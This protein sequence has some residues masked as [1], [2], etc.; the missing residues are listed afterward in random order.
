M[1]RLSGWQFSSGATGKV[2]PS[3]YATSSVL[4][5][6]ENEGLLIDLDNMFSTQFEI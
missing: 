6:V 1:Q 5:S 4:K 3:K 2:K